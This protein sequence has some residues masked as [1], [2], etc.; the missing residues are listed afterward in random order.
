MVT[1]TSSTGTHGERSLWMRETLDAVRRARAGRIPVVGYTWFPLFTMIEWKY[2]W[3]RRGLEDHLL[4]LGLF[5]VRSCAAGRMERE[6][7]PL[8]EGYR[9]CVADPAASIGEWQDAAESA[10]PTSLVA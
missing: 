1:E 9:R 8:V 10:T 6:P 2:R 5:D 7:T 3:S 4:H